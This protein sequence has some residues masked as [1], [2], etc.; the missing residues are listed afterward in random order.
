M[1]SKM[2]KV[3]S[4]RNNIFAEAYFEKGN[5]ISYKEDKCEVDTPDGTLVAFTPD[6]E[7]FE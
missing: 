2:F 1:S 4:I 3:T 6:K 7:V 5:L